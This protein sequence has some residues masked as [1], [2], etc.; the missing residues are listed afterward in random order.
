MNNYQ[1]ESPFDPEENPGFIAPL[2]YTTVT[3]IPLIDQVININQ[4][5]TLV[6]RTA[7]NNVGKIYSYNFENTPVF[8]RVILAL[9]P[10]DDYS[11]PTFFDYSFWVSDIL[12]TSTGPR[13]MKYKPS[14]QFYIGKTTGFGKAFGWIVSLLLVVFSALLLSEE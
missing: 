6:E 4:K 1:T 11:Y 10:N 5:D 8:F 12:Q 3:S 14:N 9:T 13:S 2:S 7:L